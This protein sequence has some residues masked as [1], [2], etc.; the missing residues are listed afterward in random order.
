M[1]K[2]KEFFEGVFGASAGII[3]IL[4]YISYFVGSI[5]WL[6]MSFQLGSFWM[7]FIGIAGPTVI[8]TGPVGMYSLVFGAP[9]WVL[10]TFG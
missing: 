10:S 4:F 5:Y 1:F 6:W 8:F 2:I 9:D 7:F 3:L